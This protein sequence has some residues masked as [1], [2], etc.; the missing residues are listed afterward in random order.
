[1]IGRQRADRLGPGRVERRAVG[2]RIGRVAMR[3]RLDQ[4]LL[5]AARARA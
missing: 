4:R 2:S 3:E 1:M 5:L